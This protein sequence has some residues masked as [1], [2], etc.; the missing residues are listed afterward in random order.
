MAGYSDIAGKIFKLDHIED[1]NIRPL[2]DLLRDNFRQCII[3]NTKGA[4]EPTWDYDEAIGGGTHDLSNTDLWGGEVGKKR[5]E[6]ELSHR[7]HA[8]ETKQQAR[9]VVFT[10]T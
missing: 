5:L 10:G 3:K 4:G 6:F 9:V 1:P 2:D 8:L 7:L